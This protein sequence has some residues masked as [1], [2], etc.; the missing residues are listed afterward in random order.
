MAEAAREITENPHLHI[1]AEMAALHED[2]SKLAV[3]IAAQNEILSLTPNFRGWDSLDNN[4]TPHNNQQHLDLETRYA[5]N[6]RPNN[7]S[8]ESLIENLQFQNPADAFEELHSPITLGTDE[9]FVDY[10]S[11]FSNIPRTVHDQSPLNSNNFAIDRSNTDFQQWSGNS[12][13]QVSIQSLTQSEDID[14][15][16]I[17]D[18]QIALPIS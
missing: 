5:A 11:M 7:S 10:I 2:T 1:S 17:P 9:H 3:S 12:N 15:P 8:G 16:D 14:L 6:E 4:V 18:P 13:P